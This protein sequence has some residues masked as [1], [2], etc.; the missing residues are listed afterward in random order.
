MMVDYSN[1]VAEVAALAPK[2]LSHQRLVKAEY[3]GSLLWQEWYAFPPPP[4][5]SYIHLVS[6]LGH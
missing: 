5:N 6:I 3:Q 1:G 4:Q 2:A